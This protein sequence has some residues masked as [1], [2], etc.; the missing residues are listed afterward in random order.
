MISIT[1]LTVQGQ[2][3]VVSFRDKDGMLQA[4]IISRDDISGLHLGETT[5]VP[6][7]IV[8]KGTE[9]GIEME[10]LLGDKYVIR[11]VDLEQ[12]FR[13]RGLWTYEDINSNPQLVRAAINSLS[14]RV[15]AEVLDRSRELRLEAT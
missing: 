1:L 12:E 3:A 4:R 14:G 8:D 10:V 7:L 6:T 9:Y 5:L 11:P 13:K 2:A 15:H